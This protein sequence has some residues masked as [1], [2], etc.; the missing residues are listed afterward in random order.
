MMGGLLGGVSFKAIA[1]TPANACPQRPAL[2]RLRQHRVKPGETLANIAGHYNLLSATLMGMNPAIRNGQ[3]TPGQSLSIPPYNGIVVQI[4][5]GQTLQS[6]AKLYRAKPDVLFEVNGCQTSPKIVFIPGVN[7]SPINVS[8]STPPPAKTIDKIAAVQS[9]DRYPLPQP[10]T[11]KRLY[12]W[13]PSGPN[14]AIVFSSGVDLT[15]D[16]GTPVYAVADGTIAFAGN[17][18]PWGFMVVI[19][20]AQGRQT[21]YG[22]LNAAKVKVGQSIRRGQT[23]GTISDVASAL[24]FELR[25]RNTLGWI[26]QDPQ[27]Y[28]EAI[29]KNNLKTITTPKPKQ[30]NQ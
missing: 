3:V 4:P 10:A 13:H 27:P 15:A 24:R 18:K 21:R 19:N 26:A 20:H 29:A 17:Q 8:V 6:V 1:Q 23:I 5:S 22:Y 28:L 11:I 25:H 30:K 14:Q 16:I 7:W 2:E 12:G 9:Q